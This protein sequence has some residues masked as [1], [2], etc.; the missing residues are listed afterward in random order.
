MYAFPYVHK[1]WETKCAGYVKKSYKH[2]TGELDISVSE[3]AVD[4]ACGESRFMTLEEEQD[5]MREDWLLSSANDPIDHCAT[6][7]Y[8]LYD[9]DLDGCG[10]LD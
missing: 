6:P 8:E 10:L 1:E 2:T 7:L 3:Q 5:K 4:V 9:K